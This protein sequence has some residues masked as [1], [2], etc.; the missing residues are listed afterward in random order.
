MNSK[1]S[2]AKPKKYRSFDGI[3]LVVLFLT[4]LQIFSCVNNNQSNEMKLYQIAS[5]SNA[6]SGGN[7]VFI[8]DAKGRLAKVSVLS[9]DTIYYQ[10]S[11]DSI[12]VQYRSPKVPGSADFYV[13]IKNNTG[14]ITKQIKISGTDSAYTWFNYKENYLSSVQTGDEKNKITIREFQFKNGNMVYEKYL[15]YDGSYTENV[16][17][18]D[19]NKINRQAIDEFISV[20]PYPLEN[21]LVGINNKNIMTACTYTDHAKNEKSN[22]LYKYEFDNN[23]YIMKRSSTVVNG[24]NANEY[25]ESFHYAEQIK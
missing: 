10:Y 1:V 2:I 19:T 7:K 18:Y 21:S 12:M 5:I 25:S 15:Y 9:K 6:V 4:T 23:G 20:A 14:H 3:R 17:E 8:Y 11:G 13:L 16:F 24:K 22:I